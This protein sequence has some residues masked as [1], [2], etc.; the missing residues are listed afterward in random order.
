MYASNNI[1]QNMAIAFTRVKVRH[2]R[3]PKTNYFY[4]DR[5]KI[6]GGSGIWR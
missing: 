2:Y 1:K 3:F 5:K 4:S 6:L